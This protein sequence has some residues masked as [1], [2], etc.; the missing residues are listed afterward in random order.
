MS[1]VLDI[2][3]AVSG[4]SDNQAVAAGRAKPNTECIIGASGGVKRANE[5]QRPIAD[6]LYSWPFSVGS[7]NPTYASNRQRGSIPVQQ[8]MINCWPLW[9]GSDP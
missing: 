9:P 1:A 3:V 6:G 7:D 8:Q 4:G 5:G 2:D